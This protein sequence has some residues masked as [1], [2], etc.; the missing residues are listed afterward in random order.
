MTQRDILIGTSGYSYPGAPP[1]G[2]FGAFY[3]HVKSKGFDDLKYYSN[4]FNTVEINST[5]YR[6][7]SEA[8]TKRWASKTPSDFMFAVKL[9][10]K[11]THPM[12]IGRKKPE[13]QWEAATQKDFDQFRDGI[14][15]W[16]KRES[17]VLY[18]YNTQPAFTVRL[19][20]WNRYRTL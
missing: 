2:W 15:L 16:L 18:F 20:T 8:M 11:F 6:P 4:V 7:P 19:R 9:W 13:E 3:P 5:F 17:S 1:K 10:Q 14:C 12:K